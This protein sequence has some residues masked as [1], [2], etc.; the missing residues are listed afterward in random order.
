M[1]IVRSTFDNG[2]RRARIKF[3]GPQPNDEPHGE[4]RNR[5]RVRA[6]P[7]QQ[8]P[9]TMLRGKPLRRGGCSAAS[10]GKDDA[11]HRRKFFFSL[12]FSLFSGRTGARTT[13]AIQADFEGAETLVF[14]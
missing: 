2:S 10:P 8:T 12:L 13:G 11:Q 5:S 6:A 3:I 7:R 9:S 4:T 14:A 1:A